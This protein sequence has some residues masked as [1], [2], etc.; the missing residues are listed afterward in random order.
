VSHTP[1]RLSGVRT[2]PARRKALKVFVR[3]LRID[4]FIG[5]HAHERGRAQPLVVDVELELG[6]GRIERLADT[7][8]YETVVERARAIAASGHVDLVEEY[9]ERLAAGCL[10]DPRVLSVRVR[11][12]KPE[13][14][15]GAEAAGCEVV[16]ARG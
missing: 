4:A 14:L 3:A 7:V 12:E 13:A 11:V 1:V 9:A 5:V 6:E 15:G 2:E 10:D 16:F 8:N